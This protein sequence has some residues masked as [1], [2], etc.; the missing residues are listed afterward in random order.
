[1]GAV[2][3][4]S[5]V[6]V[7]AHHPPPQ[8]DIVAVRRLENVGKDEKHMEEMDKERELYAKWKMTK[9]KRREQ[10]PALLPRGYCLGVCFSFMVLCILA[11][12]SSLHVKPCDSPALPYW[13]GPLDCSAQVCEFGDINTQKSKNC[14]ISP[15]NAVP[16]EGVLSLLQYNPPLLGRA[17]WKDVFKE[18]EP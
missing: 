8:T 16:R 12:C 17:A 9:F 10:S 14:G 6:S 4:R 7:L 5:P 1:M 3:P 15:V 13:D 2:C 11:L 18:V